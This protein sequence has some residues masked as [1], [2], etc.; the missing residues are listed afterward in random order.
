[1]GGQLGILS[2]YYSVVL[3]WRQAANMARPSGALRRYDS[4]VCWHLWYVD[5]TVRCVVGYVHAHCVFVGCC[6]CV[7]IYDCKRVCVRMETGSKHGKAVRS[8][9]KI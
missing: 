3:G 7:F 6:T 4:V 2:R 9:T 8:T 1:M 5:T